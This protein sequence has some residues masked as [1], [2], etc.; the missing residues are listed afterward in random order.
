MHKIHINN[1]TPT[2]SVLVSHKTKFYTVAVS[3][4]APKVN[5]MQKPFTLHVYYV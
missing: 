1:A 5:T 3:N 2:N 4:N